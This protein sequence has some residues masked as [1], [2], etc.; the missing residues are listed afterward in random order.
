MKRMW[1]ALMAALVP[2]ALAQTVPPQDPP[3]EPLARLRLEVRARSA[4]QPLPGLA[5]R[6][7]RRVAGGRTLPLSGLGSSRVTDAQGFAAFDGLER[8]GGALVVSLTEPKMGVRLEFPLQEEFLE[9]NTVRVGS[10][11]VKLEIK[12]GTP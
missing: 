1:I 7:L 2:L 3:T 5:I 9:P 12:R 6:L 10:L 4:G 11:E 8:A